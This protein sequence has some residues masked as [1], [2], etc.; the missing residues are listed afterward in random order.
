MAFSIILY[1]SLIIF[2]A[3]L[4]YRVSRWFSR[5]V[6]ISDV[7]ISTSMRISSFIN[8]LLKTIFSLNL[9]RLIKSFFLDVLLQIQILK[10][11]P[12]RWIM[13]IFIYGGFMLLLLMHALGGIITASL[14]SDYYSTL[15]PF[16][17]LRNIFG[18]LVII[19][20]AIAFYRRNILKIPRLKTSPMD[21]YAVM[22]LAVI[23]ISG[24]LLEGIK[25]SSHTVF[26]EM[27]EEYS[28]VDIED[29]EEVNALESLWVKDFGLVSPYVS[30]PFDEEIIEQGVE[31]HEMNCE[32][33]HSAP[34]WAFGGYA[35]SRV[36]S[37]VAVTFDRTGVVDILYYIHILACFIGL[38]YLPFSKMFHIVA[39]PISLLANSVMETEK[40]NPANIATRQVM[41][42]DACTHCCTC[43]LYCSAMMANKVRGNDFILPS[44][45]MAFLKKIVAGKKVTQEEF[46]AIQEGVYLCSNCDRCTVVCPS[47]I[48]LRDLWLNVREGLIQKGVPEPLLLSPFSLVRGLRRESIDQENYL[49]P[50]TTTRAKLKG[51]FE[52]LN[53]PVKPISF[54]FETN[55]RKDP[56]IQD[57]TFS[58]CFGCTN[59]TSVC[60]VVGSFDNPQEAL[61][62]LPH[63]IM[64][65]LGLGLTEM[66]SGPNMLWDCVTCYQCQEH[67]PQNVKVTDILYDLKNSTMMN[68]QKLTNSM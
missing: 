43:S 38:A 25:I 9:F 6:G 65:C 35:V 68:V 4:V 56:K 66:A 47:G 50:L 7:S 42:L 14:F 8:G 40:S 13:H 34:Q 51:H 10:E 64:C 36:I 63:Q 3:G 2:L 67:C 44:E 33:C 21:R 5:T 37:P 41:E 11:D 46:K 54:S 23:M 20:I 12:L 55:N 28:D 19:G 16:F 29:E 15:N 61:G 22:I 24:F 17:F 62:L 57:S 26:M 48:N 30:G 39:T 18:I 58:C 52:S 53:D 60:P 1:T 31:I 59:C 45:K 49:T 32:G 27:I